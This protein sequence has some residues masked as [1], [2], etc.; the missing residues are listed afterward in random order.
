[1]DDAGGAAET[2][3]GGAA[4]ARCVVP[5][6][7]GAKLRNAKLTL[8]ANGC[9]VGKVKRAKGRGVKKGRV[10]RQS[11]KAGRSFAPGTKI[12]IRVRR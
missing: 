12:N 10:L 9:R 11:R 5:K 8:R 6:L 2:A 3:A 4:N 1:M 7:R